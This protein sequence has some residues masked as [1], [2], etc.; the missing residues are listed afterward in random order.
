M[1][2][3]IGYRSRCY[4]SQTIQA[5]IDGQWAA[6]ATYAWGCCN[7]LKLQP[8]VGNVTVGAGWLS[9]TWQIWA[10]QFNWPLNGNASSA[11]NADTV[12][13]YHMN[14][15]VLTT[16]SPTFAAGTLVGNLNVST[17]NTT[18]GWI[19]LADD[20]DIVDLNDWYAAMRF[21]QWVRIHAW[22]STG[23]PVITL[24]SNGQVTA[25]QFNWPLNGNA[26]T[27]TTFSTNNS[28]YKGITD[29][30]VAGL[31]M[32]KNYGNNHTIFD[33]SNSTSPAGW[34]VNN[35]NSQVAWS[36]TYPTLMWWNGANT[37]GVRVDS[38]RVADGLSNM[39][40]SQ[41]TNNSA[42]ITD[43]N[44][45]WDNSYGFL[46][47]WFAS[48]AGQPASTTIA[49]E[50]GYGA[51]Q[52]VSQWN[53]G[54][55][56]AAFMS[57]HRPN[58]YATYF[59]LDTDNQFKVGWWSMGAVSYPLILGNGYTN[60][61]I[62]TSWDITMNKDAPTLF[63]IDTNEQTAMIHNNGNLLYFLGWCWVNSPTWCTK[64]NFAWVAGY[65]PLYI[66]MNNNDAT[67]GWAVN[68]FGYFYLSD[69]RL[70]KN[71]KKIDSPLDKIL[72]LSGYT[73]EWKNSGKKS[74]WL[75]AQEV[76]KVFPDLVSESMN[77]SGTSYKTVEYG[78]MTAPLIE[79]VK[80]LK[81]EKDTE[82]EELRNEN[83]ELKEVVCLDHPEAQICK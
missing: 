5:Y 46:T 36:A 51:F 59:G 40:I 26:S 14:Q 16:S 35:T 28:N 1:K 67:F 56:G 70:K 71:I 43:G 63:F 68:A 19:K 23:W 55:A 83:R 57:F 24:A 75:I 69:E 82:I 60:W 15:N 3:L 54:T 38:A 25:S 33:A 58:A 30:A 77:G 4:N 64:T 27:A 9:T 62:R 53:A 76:E 7:T 6:R 41:F 72:S 78:N 49:N 61:T 21:S 11:T 17:S 50:T 79:A 8:D 20:G 48:S 44:T 81:S 31:L 47:A 65:W 39:N 29:G 10:A 45:N 73:F 13:G 42:Y 18:G 2:W 74:V 80:E 52:A 12:D 34:A 22:N 32:W 37:Y 66:N